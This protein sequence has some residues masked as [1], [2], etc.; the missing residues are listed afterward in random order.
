MTMD[1]HICPS[2]F[3]SQNSQCTNQIVYY[4]LCL[5]CLIGVWNSLTPSQI[6]NG[7]D[8]LCHNYLDGEIYVPSHKLM[9]I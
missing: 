8:N 7:N 2:D 9:C 4:I 3:P 6:S 1:V 5:I